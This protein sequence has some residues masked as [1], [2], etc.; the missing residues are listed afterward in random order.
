[1]AV[2]KSITTTKMTT[3]MVK[4]IK[5]KLLIT[6]RRMLLHMSWFQEKKYDKQLQNDLQKQDET[7]QHHQFDLEKIKQKPSCKIIRNV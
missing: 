4:V 1:M 3:K 6:K 7:K 2:N 5:K